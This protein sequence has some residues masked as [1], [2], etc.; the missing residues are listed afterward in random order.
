MT[1]AEHRKEIA[2]LMTDQAHVQIT[3]QVIREHGYPGNEGLGRWKGR[4]KAIIN[5]PAMLVEL[6]NGVKIMLPLRF[7]AEAAEESTQDA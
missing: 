6:D 3:N 2:R 4:I 7:T 5:E 1:P